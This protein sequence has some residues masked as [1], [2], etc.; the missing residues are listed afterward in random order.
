MT[1]DLNSGHANV[2]I[3]RK[4]WDNKGFL[5]HTKLHFRLNNSYGKWGATRRPH[6]SVASSLARG[7]PAIWAAFMRRMK[8][9]QMC[10]INKGVVFNDSI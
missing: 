8:A 9:A 6:P 10:K 2:S 3:L 1:W 4:K 7:N 5:H